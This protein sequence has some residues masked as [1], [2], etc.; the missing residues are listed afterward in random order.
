MA[1]KFKVISKKYFNQYRNYDFATETWTLNATEFTDRLQGNVGET[2]YLEEEIQ[3]GTIVNEEKGVEQEYIS[4]QGLI[5]SAFYDYE[6]EGLY[7]ELKKRRYGS[8][9]FSIL[10]L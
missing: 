8:G 7:K 5:S 9:R 10:L 3:V 4:S 1:N 6:K 2:L